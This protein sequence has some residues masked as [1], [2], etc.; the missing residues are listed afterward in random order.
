MAAIDL[1]ISSSDGSDS[2]APVDLTND[3]PSPSMSQWEQIEISPQEQQLWGQLMHAV[4]GPA[5]TGAGAGAAA[6]SS[7]D[8]FEMEREADFAWLHVF[9]GD[10]ETWQDVVDGINAGGGASSEDSESTCARKHERQKLAQTFCVNGSGICSL[11]TYS[12][13]KQYV[14]D[15]PQDEDATKALA[16]F[17]TRRQQLADK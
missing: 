9:I 11:E 12:K 16:V 7:K 6:A 15:N 13:L 10:E 1:T 4:R 14:K 2:D 3:S 17:D 8:R 5:T